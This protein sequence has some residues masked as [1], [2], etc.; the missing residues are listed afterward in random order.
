MVGKPVE[1]AAGPDR[2]ELLAVADSDQL[3]S[4][5]LH[6]PGQSIEALELLIYSP[7]TVRLA[8][9]TC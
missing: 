6:E 9:Y 8:G 7:E 1:H 5:A 3:R 4:R 2:G